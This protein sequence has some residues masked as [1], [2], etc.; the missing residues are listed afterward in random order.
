MKR[1]GL[2]LVIACNI[3]LSTA[4][5]EDSNSST[6]NPAININP[7]P[8]PPANQ[9]GPASALDIS[10]LKSGEQ[11]LRV[12]HYKQLP[13]FFYTDIN[14][15]SGF[16]YEIFSQVAK[17][18]GIQKVNFI[19][20]ENNIDLNLLLEH[21]AID[22]IANSWDLPGMRKHFLL[23]TPYYTK[24]G[25]S[26]LFFKQKGN[27][28]KAEDL[29]EHTIGVF[30]HGY[31]DLYWLPSHGIAKDSIKA[32]S[33]IKEL[34]T[35]LR[36]GD[37]DVAVIYYPLAK[38][39]EQQLPDQLQAVLVEPI[40]DVYAVRMQDMELAK[41]LNQAIQTLADNG[42]LTKIQADYLNPTEN[43]AQNNPNHTT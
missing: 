4:F 14:D 30:K 24:G 22:V 13:P 7:T 38:L 11:V 6:Q 2:L 1:T 33:N 25:L 9:N 20:F 15:Q 39:A 5:G 40:N 10:K 21:G 27:Y 3:V 28:Q 16:G 26:F 31:A 18:A 37:I 36:E 43:V 23:S 19:G 35:A 41:I 32:F 29:K 17:Q 34:M 12:G 8:P 42:T